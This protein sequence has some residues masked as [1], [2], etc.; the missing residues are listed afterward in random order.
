M[1]VAVLLSMSTAVYADPV[2]KKD[3]FWDKLQN[4]FEKLVPAKKGATTTAVGG[5]RGAKNDGAADIY[6]KGKDKAVEMSDEEHQKFNLG[7]EAKLK[8][9]NQLA[10]KHFE[11]FLAQYPQSNFRVEGLQAAEKLRIEV[12]EAKTSVSGEP[13]QQP[14]ATVTQPEVAVEPVQQSG[15]AAPEPAAEAQPAR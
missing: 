13:R 7:V 10:L 5:V 8:G 3:P 15:T 4:K 1:F 6:W 11:E 2:P 14:P 9:D 12:S